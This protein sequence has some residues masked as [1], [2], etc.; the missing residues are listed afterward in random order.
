MQF[1]GEVSQSDDVGTDTVVMST[2]KRNTLYLPLRTS[3][4]DEVRSSGGYAC[5]V[6]TPGSRE[7]M[8]TGSET[9]CLRESDQYTLGTQWILVDDPS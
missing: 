2:I 4:N 3:S 1:I 6:V 7:R 8:H 9:T 5:Y